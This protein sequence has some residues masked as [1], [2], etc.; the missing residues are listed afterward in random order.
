M[1]NFERK[2]KWEW[3]AILLAIILVWAFCMHP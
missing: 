1:N 3:V 2:V